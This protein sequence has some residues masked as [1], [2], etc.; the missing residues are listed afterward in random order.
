MKTYIKGNY[1]KSIYESDQ[2]YVIGIFKVRDTNSETMADY[3]NKTITFTGYFHDLNE[4][5][6]YFFYGEEVEHPRYGFQFQVTE[7]ERVKPEDKSGLIEFFASDLFPG[8]GEKIA[9][10]IVETLG[11]DAIDKIIN[12][13]SVLTLVPNLTVKKMDKIYDVLLK[14]E[15]G[16]QTIVYLSELGFSMKDALSIYNKYKSETRNKIEHDI[17]RLLDDLED[18]KF[19]KID[20]I[21]KSMNMAPDDKRRVKACIIYVMDSLSYRNGDVYLD[22]STI[23]T[24]VINYLDYTIDDDLFREYLEELMTDERIVIEDDKYYLNELWEAEENVADKIIYL[25]SLDTTKYSKLDNYISQLEKSNGIYYNDKQKEAIIKALEN[26]VLI[27]TGGPGT[28]KTTVINAIVELYTQLNKFDYESLTEKLALLAPTGRA[29]KRMSETTNLPAMTIH[30]FLKWN[31]EANS[32]AVNEYDKANSHLVIVDEVSMIDINLLDNLLK[33]LSKNIKLI[34]VGDYNQLPSVGPG[35]VLKDLIDSDIIDTVH[36]D[37]LYRQDEN[38]YINT[39]ALE[40]K[41]DDLSE[42]FLET[43]SDYTFLECNST[44]LKHNLKNLCQQIY[45][46]GY[47]YKRV[48]VMAPMYYGENGIDNLNK[49]LQSIFNPP[50]P[51]KREINFGDVVFRENDKV[52]QLVNMPDE[53]VYNGDI[54][55]IKSIV[56]ANTSKKQKNEIHIDFDGNIVKYTHKDF[57]KIKH[58]FIISIHKSQGSEFEVVIIPVCNS[59]RRMLY[60]KL[61][62]TGITRAKK[63]L[64]L[65]GEPAAF[66]YSVHNNNEYIRKTS[67]LDKILNKLNNMSK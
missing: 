3:V 36:L 63:K 55:V 16:H 53:N 35:Q 47:D 27:I 42:G 30:R 33:G 31:K 34:L 50:D 2:G 32:F 23:L 52:L 49:E 65:I 20:E 6:T 57:I 59:Y 15:E 37:L 60:R 44:S 40:I 51:S 17:F 7:Y 14:Y 41:D 67:L 43:K 56:Y 11:K 13:K 4:D 19:V 66:V 8:I 1:R 12:D 48:Q 25:A 10:N 45:D 9:T 28:G 54:G 58:G 24:S 39:L 5:D 26:N 46:K 29:S 21:S 61:I 64:I 62:Y 22:Y 18:I 38:S